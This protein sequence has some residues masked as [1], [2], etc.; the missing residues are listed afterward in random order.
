[1]AKNLTI[2]HLYPVQDYHPF[3]Q[4]I[5]VR[6]FDDYSNSSHEGTNLGIK[7]NA[8]PEGPRLK[9]EHATCILS[10]NAEMKRVLRDKQSSQDGTKT[11]NSVTPVF[12]ILRSVK[13][14]NNHFTC[15]CCY[16]ERHGIACR[17]IFNV[18]SSF[19]SYDEPTHHDVS[20]RYFRA[21]LFYP[22]NGNRGNDVSKIMSLLVEKDTRGPSCNSSLFEHIVIVPDLP[23]HFRFNEPFCINY[24]LSTATF[25]SNKFFGNIISSRHTFRC[26]NINVTESQ[27]GH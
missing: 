16:F 14:N 21:F 15:S 20:I 26:W 6:R 25:D 1:M 13:Y 24:D 2:G 22:P 19:D 23:N 17:Q 10:K 11:H 3:Y 27:R 9:L 5:S 8:A 12:E 4:R 18:L 7:Y